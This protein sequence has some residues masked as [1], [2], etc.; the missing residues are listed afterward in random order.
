MP[1]EKYRPCGWHRP[2]QHVLVESRHGGVHVAELWAAQ[3]DGLSVLY[4]CHTAEEAEQMRL[5]LERHREE[6]E[7]LMR[8]WEGS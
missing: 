6:V 7:A 2:K 3:R 1:I 4:I 8:K 5:L